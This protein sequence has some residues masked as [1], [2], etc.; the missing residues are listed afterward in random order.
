[1]LSGLKNFAIRKVIVHVAENKKLNAATNLLAVI[2]V[3]L[4]ALLN[5]N[6]DWTKLLAGDLGEIARLIVPV[7]AAVI[8][9]FTGKFSWLKSWIPT[10]NEILTEAGKELAEQPPQAKK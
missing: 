9:W 2:P 6:T 7:G 1:M 4:W 10:L 5:N 3:I 8:L